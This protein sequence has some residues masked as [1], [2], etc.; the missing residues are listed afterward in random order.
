MLVIPPYKCQRD[1]KL[2][3]RRPCSQGQGIYMGANS[4]RIPFQPRAE[5]RALKFFGD[6]F[7]DITKLHAPSLILDNKDAMFE[8]YTK[9]KDVV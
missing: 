9:T 7:H 3:F 6:C 4:L 2:V 5:K 8:A 1:P